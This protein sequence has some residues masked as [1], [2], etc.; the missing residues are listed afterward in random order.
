MRKYFPYFLWILVFAVDP[1]QAGDLTVFGGFQNPGD[2]TLTGL[3]STSGQIT[4]PGDFGVFGVRL[5]AS[6]GFMG[7]EST[8]GYSPRF[9]DDDAYSVLA[10]S[11]FIIGVPATTIRPYATAGL[12]IVYAGG[13]G[14]ASFGLRFAFNYGGGVKVSA[15]MLG[16]RIDIRGYSIPGLQSQTLGIFET[17]VGLLVSF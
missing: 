5:N 15:G 12:G 16:V 3:G 11:N 10:N 17:S 14:P 13:N 6:P 7:V 1:A 2:I 9:L 8:V 4:H